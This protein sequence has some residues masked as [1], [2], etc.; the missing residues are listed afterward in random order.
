MPVD[1]DAA[2][3][4]AIKDLETVLVDREVHF[5]A[6]ALPPA[7]GDAAMIQRVW[8]N[9]LGDAVRSTAPKAEVT[10]EIGATGGTTRLCIIHPRQRRRFRHASSRQ[11]FGLFQRLHGGLAG[12]GIG[13]AIVKRIV[14]R[15][16]GR[17]WAEGK[18]N[19]GP[20][21]I[22]PC[23]PQRGSPRPR[24]EVASYL[25]VGLWVRDRKLIAVGQHFQ[26][27]V[28]ASSPLGDS[29]RPC[30]CAPA[31]RRTPGLRPSA[32]HEWRR[33]RFD[34]L[35]PHDPVRSPTSGGCLV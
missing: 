29:P 22:S 1:M 35:R 34:R 16:G 14:A 7:R 5:V 2:V 21:S 6:G 23:L 31:P 24:S 30:G 26:Q 12:T 17:V 4:A 9:L 25:R 15:H 32:L 18:R 8:A 13:L 10:I 33:C 3:Q 11:A 19:R 27:R 20:V 28:S